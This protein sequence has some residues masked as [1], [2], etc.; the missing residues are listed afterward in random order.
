MTD[1]NDH[2]DEHTEALLFHASQENARQASDQRDLAMLGISPRLARRDPE[3]AQVRDHS[4]Q[5]ED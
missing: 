4:W 1:I 3:P 2:D 5:W